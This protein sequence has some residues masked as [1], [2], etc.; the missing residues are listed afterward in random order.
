[1]KKKNPLNVCQLHTHPTAGRSRFQN[2]IIR[3]K[4]DLILLDVQQSIC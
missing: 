1:M 4:E 3:I 2:I